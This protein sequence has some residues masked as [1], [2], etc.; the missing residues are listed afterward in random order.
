MIQFFVHRDSRL[1]VLADRLVEALQ[2]ERPANPLAAQTVVVAHPGL[3]RWLRQLIAREQGIAANFH[4]PQPWQWLQ[5]AAQHALGDAASDDGAWR[6]EFLRWRIYAALPRIDQPVVRASLAGAD[7]ELRRFR[8]AERLAGLYAQ[9]LIYR[10]DWI[11]AWERGK[12]A[13]NWQAVLWRSLCETIAAPHRAQR[14]REL[15]EA[16]A[17]AGDGATGPLHVFGVSHLPPDTLDALIATSARRAVHLYFPDPCRAYW[18]DMRTPR[19]MLERG[20]DADALYFEIGHPLLVS[21]G[22][23]AQDFLLALDAR[24]IEFG[25][26]EVPVEAEPATLLGALQMSL[27]DCEPQRMGAA[28]ALRI[29]ASLRVHVCATRLRELEVLRDALL[30][31]L[32]DNH[33]WQ[34]RDIVVMAPDIGAYAP[35]LPAVFGPPAH[36]SHDRSSIPWHLADVNLASA[37][38]LLRAFAQLLELAESRFGLSEVL[39]LLDVPALARRAHLHTDDRARL[40][41]RMRGAGVA[42]GLDARAK[43]LSGAAAVAAN[44]W[45][46]GFDRLFAG[47]IAGED[48]DHALLDEILPLAFP[49]SDDAAALGRLHQFVESLHR[50]AAGFA[51]PRTL[52]AWCAWLHER[53]DAL[54]EVDPGDTGE[55]AALD[56]LRRVL[57]DLRAQGEAGG[58]QLL[59][60][61]VMRETLRGALSAV[62]EHQPFLL[63]GVTFCGLVPQRSIPFRVVCL[64]GMNEGEFPRPGGDEGLNRML[65]HPRHGDRDTRREDRQLFL[66]ALMAARERLHISFLGRDVENGKARNPAAPLAELL[67]F[68]D[69]QHGISGDVDTVARPWRIEHALQPDAAKYYDG[70][71]PA[72]FSFAGAYAER[73]SVL[74][75]A[76]P[77]VDWTQ[78]RN[79]APAAGTASLQW[80]KRFW[81]DPAMA[82]L[83]DDA[84]V[85]LSAL[86]DDESLDR[87]PLQ[88]KPDRR[89]RIESR[90]LF[91]ALAAGQ[92]VLSPHAPDWLAFS[93]HI[94]S[95]TIGASAYSRARELAQP[96]LDAARKFLGD[97]A[98]REAQFVELDCDGIRVSG[99]V[100][101]TFR[102]SDGKLRLFGA[103]IGKPAEFA[104]L[105]PFYL[106]WACLQ[107]G[108]VAVD[109]AHWVEV[110]K[111]SATT[112]A[113]K[114]LAAILAQSD[115][116]LRSGLQELLR[117][118][119]ESRARPVLFPPRTAWAWASADAAKRLDAAARAWAGDDGNTGERD[120]APGYAAL[121][122]RGMDFLDA[123][124]PAGREFAA[125]VARVLAIL[126]PSTTASGA[127]E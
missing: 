90:L 59:P 61:S 46:F 17:R 72:L 49:G 106:D 69:E 56:A 42:W 26:D 36:Y 82:Q 118:A 112:R 13:G 54:F 24:R 2:C 9:Y 41:R 98:R 20:D 62:P 117:M 67:Q 4:F 120:Y 32:A 60:W 64:V 48:T 85:S 103:R 55:S 25:A 19:A 3:G 115:A 35:L 100:Q 6:R 27:R 95:G 75:A 79:A 101:D 18:A 71:D 16:L 83:R 14:Q 80:L 30:R 8:L 52:A 97:A 11:A 44:S 96:A 73:K 111:D 92:R 15:L 127:R 50:L 57:V 107:R 108:G 31:F 63:G 23:M 91:D 113:P 22:R 81:R 125:A 33:E 89:E 87:E 124:T 1:E 119:L 39:D 105:L 77:F 74:D 40:E 110:D 99:T 53:I 104:Q 65:E 21:L 88:S 109:G 93:G 66:E 123:N 121:L 70:D 51:V 116:Q 28:P 45:Q 47:L 68:L 10:P 12:E 29:D 34:P 84:G 76:P 78:A 86:D 38:P 58:K 126:D 43:Q 102:C 94:A 5:R 114:L 7:A 122:A 37:H